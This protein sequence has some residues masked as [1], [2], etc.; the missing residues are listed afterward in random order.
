MILNCLSSISIIIRPCRVFSE[1]I[2]SLCMRTFYGPMLVIITQTHFCMQLVNLTDLIVQSQNK[3]RE[4]ALCQLQSDELSEHQAKI[5][6]RSCVSQRDIQR[7]F[8][9][10]QWIKASYTRYQP[11]GARLDYV[12]RAVLVAL[13]IVYYMRLNSKYRKKYEEY[14]DQQPRI[15]NEVSFSQVKLECLSCSYY[16]SLLAN[17]AT[18]V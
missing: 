5:F 18:Y 2:S 7:V 15:P 10:Y 17:L 14:L 12:R 1:K 4:Y 6:S 13:G 3:M 11:Y 16:Q 8:T 9:L